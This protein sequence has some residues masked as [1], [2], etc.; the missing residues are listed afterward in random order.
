MLPLN[1]AILKLFENG[2]EY[3]TPAV[4]KIL[5]KDYGNYKAFK[6]ASIEESLMS[7]VENGL[8]DEKSYRLD[9]NKELIVSYQANEY[10]IDMIKK[11]I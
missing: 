6:P 9:E 3:D 2:E 4:I 1:Y 5:K 10:G 11:Y 8:L 7:A